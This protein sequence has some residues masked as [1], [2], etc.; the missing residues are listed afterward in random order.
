[1]N[2]PLTVPVIMLMGFPVEVVVLY[3]VIKSSIS[4][5][6]HS[7]TRLPEKLDAVLRYFIITPDFHRIHHSSDRKY[8]DSHFSEA[9][10]VWDY[11]F[12]TT[13]KIPYA[14]HE[15]MQL[16]LEYFR[17]K[18]DGRLDKLLLR[19]FIWKRERNKEMSGRPKTA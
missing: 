14:Q 17:G 7:N 11:L 4:I 13:S 18:K 6:A 15:S 16:G 2:V 12:G 8:T 9:F 10:P 5:F 19:P 3:Q 1:M